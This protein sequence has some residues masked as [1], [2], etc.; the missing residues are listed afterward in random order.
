[1]SVLLHRTTSAG[2]GDAMALYFYPLFYVML[3]IARNKLNP[4]LWDI[5]EKDVET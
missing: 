3:T 2:F 1:M 5:K 4:I